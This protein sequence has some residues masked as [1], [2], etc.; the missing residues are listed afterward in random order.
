VARF[1]P[2]LLLALFGGWCGTVAW[3]AGSWASVTAA[4]SL[5]GMLLWKGSPWRDPLGLGAAGSL[6]P[7]AL[8]ITM[9]ASL[10]A[11]PV[12]RAGWMGVLLFPV[13][14]WLPG[15]VAR[16]WRREADLRWGLRGL[17][18][19]VAA[20]ALWSLV[21]WLL[22]GSPRP[23]M[24]LGHHN[25]LAAWLVILLP[26]ALVPARE[27][28]PWRRVA[29]TAG[30]LA[31]VAVVAS[32]SLTGTAALTV[33]ALLALAWLVRS[34][35]WILGLS[36]ALLLA[37]LGLAAFQAPRLARI[38]SG[39]DSS[40]QARTSYLEAGWQGFLA[41]PVLGWGPGSA[42]WTLSSFLTP[43]PGVNPWGEAVG[44]L[45]SLPLH[46][47]YELGA[48]GLLLALA[49]F[50]LFVW[51]RRGWRQSRAPLPLICA[52]LGF[53]GAAVASLANASIAVPALPLALAVAAGAALAGGEAGPGR[54]LPVRLYALVAA[55]ALAPLEL[56]RWH[57][58]RAA[59]A[60]QGRPD[61]ARWEVA[62]AVA[63]DPLFPLYRMRLALLQGTAGEA[64]R[65]ARE[66][67][68]V[69][70]LWTVA[71]ALGAPAQLPWAEAALERACVLQPFDPFPPYYLMLLRQ[72][73][74]RA[75]THGAHALLAEPRLAAA[76][77][78]ESHGSLLSQSL[79]VV[80]RWPGVDPGWRE[81]LIAAS[82]SPQSQG[83]PAVRLALEIDT[84]PSLSLSLPIF[85]RRPW[86]V[87][88]PLVRVRQDLL[89][90][91][92]LPPA[93]VLPTTSASAFAAEVCRVSR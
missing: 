74:E 46:L 73:G 90:P 42:P 58:D 61:L 79:E 3:G 57:Y 82:P 67:G 68:S 53:L 36:L 13:Y 34:R 37:C 81:V 88:W 87:Q 48:T 77:F 51:R 1:A 93:T 86:P 76:V 39:D 44:D 29:L 5:L 59:T 30:G 78:W 12:P 75:A 31:V 24:P 43:V 80:R 18:A 35:R 64:L 9:V 4:A 17:A 60:S 8:W 23:A 92:A 21:D 33:Q 25:L 41:R 71:G 54:E 28:G 11:S 20:V 10:W 55:L 91:L 72:P 65:A 70:V 47:A 85:R 38:A 56:A 16:C 40:A 19:V 84:I 62:R 14:L 89:D 15:A 83:G 50:L 2:I 45:H 22:L 63:L 66:A 49:T 6:L 69:P 26:L 52:L 27:P 32:R 7:W